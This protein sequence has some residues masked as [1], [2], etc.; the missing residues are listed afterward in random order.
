MKLNK[1]LM[2]KINSPK[3]LFIFV[4]LII[5]V[6]IIIHFVFKSIRV[7]FDMDKKEENKLSNAKLTANNNSGNNGGNK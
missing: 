2:N 7:I 6:I 4:F 5:V 1:Q 3:T